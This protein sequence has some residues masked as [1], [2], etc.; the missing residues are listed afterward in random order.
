MK[1]IPHTEYVE[2]G[3]F[4]ALPYLEEREFTVGD[5]S[6]RGGETYKA[7]GKIP[8]KGYAYHK[9]N[10]NKKLPLNKDDF[11]QTEVVMDFLRLRDANVNY[12]NVNNYEHK[13]VGNHITDFFNEELRHKTQNSNGVSIDKIWNDKE[14]RK[15]LYEDIYSIKRQALHLRGDYNH[16]TAQK[17]IFGK[18]TDKD[19][20]GGI[21]NIIVSNNQFRPFVA[22]VVYNYFNKHMGGITT[23][24]D[25]S[26]GWGGRMVGAL[27]LDLDY[28]G[29]DPNISLKKS[30]AGILGLLKPYNK[31]KAD[32]YFQYAENFDFSRLKYDFVLTSPPYIKESG[33]LT[34]IYENMKDYSKDS[35]YYEFLI[36]TI[37]RIMY[38]LPKN[39][40]CCI[41]THESNIL[42]LKELLLGEEDLKIPYKT[43]ERAGQKTKRMSGENKAERYSEYIYA[44]KNTDSRMKTIVKNLNKHNL[45]IMLKPIAK[46]ELSYPIRGTGNNDFFNKEGISISTKINK[47]RR[48]ALRDKL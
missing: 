13:Y 11:N 6:E 3:Q 8:F 14:A 47:L 45:N 7:Y 20:K 23:V 30:Y 22:K 10:P 24:L 48:E 9:I 42:I 15:K 17:D 46:K 43:K 16:K 31:G 36:P 29:I 32:L 33:N 34:E 18:L 39:K 21:Q 38:Y 25:F 27:S 2:G 41:N 19:I 40:F 26:A 4:K 5:W 37:Y 35:F 12:D 44:F 28:I 1:I